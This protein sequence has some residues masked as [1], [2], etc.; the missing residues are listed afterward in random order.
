MNRGYGYRG[1]YYGGYRSAYYG[2]RFYGG[3]G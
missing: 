2:P 3:Y 1:A